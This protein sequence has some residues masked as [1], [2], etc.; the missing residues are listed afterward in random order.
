MMQVG[1]DGGVPSLRLHMA[2]SL[3]HFSLRKNKTM[4]KYDGDPSVISAAKFKATAAAGAK[5]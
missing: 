3:L 1:F 2:A 4:K 5:A